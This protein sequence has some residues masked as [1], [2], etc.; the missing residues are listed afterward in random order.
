MRQ[1]SF[2]TLHAAQWARFEQLLA[3]TTRKKR[4]RADGIVDG[5]EVTRAD[6]VTLPA[7]YRDITHQLSIA[8]S[9]GYSLGLISRLESLALR[10][11]QVLYQ[12]RHPFFESLLAFLAHGFPTQ[13][14]DAWRVVA[15]SAGLFFGSIVFAAGLVSIYPDTVLTLIEPNALRQIE[16]M[17]DPARSKLGRPRDAG[18][19]IAM[20]GFYI[21]NNTG[22][23]FQTFA[24]GIVA[25]LGTLFFLLFNGLH[26]GAIGGHLTMQGFAAPFWSFVAGHSAL[27]LTAIVISGAAGLRLGWP[28]LSPGSRTRAR[29][30]VEGA[31][32]A[33]G[34]VYG[35]AGLFLLAAFVEAFWSSS[36]SLAA[37]LKYAVGGL[38]WVLLWSY[39]LL[40]G[41]GSN[42]A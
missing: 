12:R 6:L 24:G 33:V 32:S 36:A 22:I 40:A 31:R 28:L 21:R 1:D 29:A 9:R 27:E 20:F 30:L 41:R 42:G 25:G 17:Y 26:I 19:D 39:L 15:V 7:E 23:G 2:C 18:D 34:L 13:F 10:G 14:R 11:H 8:R 16:D 4:H 35:A 5:S 37:E 38:L 3:L